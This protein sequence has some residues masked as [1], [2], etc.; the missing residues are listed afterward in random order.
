MARLAVVNG[1]YVTLNL[2]FSYI[3]FTA[4]HSNSLPLRTKVTVSD[5]HIM[6]VILFSLIGLGLFCLI[7]CAPE[8]TP[9]SPK[10]VS[11][12]ER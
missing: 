5:S 10:D 12:F 8:R 1:P 7:L 4:C 11:Y 9:R 6:Q 3:H 2:F